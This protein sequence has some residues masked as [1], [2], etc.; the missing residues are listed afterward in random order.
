M[1]FMWVSS[2]QKVSHSTNR[3]WQPV[4]VASARYRHSKSV[5]W[6]TPHSSAAHSTG[7]MGRMSMMKETQTGSGVQAVF[8]DGAREGVEPPTAAA[9]APLR[10]ADSDRAVPPGAESAAPRAFLVRSIGC[11]GLGERADTDLVAAVPLVDVFSEHQEVVGGQARHERPKGVRAS[12]MDLPHPSE[13]PPGGIVA[14]QKTRWALGQ[15]LC[16]AGK[17]IAFGDLAVPESTPDIQA[18]RFSNYQALR[19]L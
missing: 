1:S 19:Q 11:C 14:K 8:E 6:L 16:L 3:S 4:I 17:S 9:A 10:N 2:I 7:T 12:H 13:R 15:I 5:L 18:V